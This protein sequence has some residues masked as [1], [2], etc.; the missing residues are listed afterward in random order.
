MSTSS[1][2]TLTMSCLLV[3]AALVAPPGV[4]VAQDAA[5]PTVSVFRN[6]NNE[7]R[8]TLDKSREELYQGM[9]P[10]KRD[11]IEHIQDRSGQAN[12]L[13][14]IGLLV[15]E[16]RT[17]VFIQST[18]QASYEMTR[19]EDGT[20]MTLIFE[21]ARVE[22]RNL[23][24]LIDA[25]YYDRSVKRIDPARKRQAIHVVLTVEPEATPKINQRGNYLYI[26]FPHTPDQ[27]K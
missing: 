12:Q 13:N 6:Q 1:L 27:L 19:S 20:Q 18:Q 26:D 8:V 2:T 25:S 9:I 11:T 23:M 5:T 14:W 17:R 10:G 24:R 22:N 21:G 15:E 4:A 16:T 7:P 3:A